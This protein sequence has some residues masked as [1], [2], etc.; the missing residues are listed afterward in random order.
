MGQENPRPELL[1]ISSFQ[2]QRQFGPAQLL[3]IHSRK[4]QFLSTINFKGGLELFSILC[5]YSRNGSTFTRFPSSSTNDWVEVETER[6]SVRNAQK[7]QSIKE[8]SCER[9]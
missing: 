8:L 5:N 7:N 6:F 9:H 3:G 1:I 2:A 4:T